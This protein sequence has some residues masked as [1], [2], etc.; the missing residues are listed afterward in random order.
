M[1]AVSLQRA[2]SADDIVMVGKAVLDGLP[3]ELRDLVSHV[4]IRVEDWPDETVLDAMEIDDP[5]DVTVHATILPSLSGGPRLMR[6]H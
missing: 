5:L 3:A 1:S 6:M 2:P 4:P